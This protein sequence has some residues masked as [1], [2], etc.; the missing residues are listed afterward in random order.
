MKFLKALFIGLGTCIVALI[1]PLGGLAV[2]LITISSA[3]IS[4]VVDNLFNKK[5]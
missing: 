1:A 2:G 3:I 4:W 5:K